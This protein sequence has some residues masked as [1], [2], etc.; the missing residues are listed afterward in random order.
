MEL[1]WFLTVPNSVPNS[2]TLKVP[3]GSNRRIS[4]KVV[5]F[6]NRNYPQLGATNRNLQG[7]GCE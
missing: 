3:L 6:L 4:K 7:N 5:W 2:V 1:S